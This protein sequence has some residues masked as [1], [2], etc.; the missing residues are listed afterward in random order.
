[1]VSLEPKPPNQPPPRRQAQAISFRA[2]TENPKRL[3][4]HREQK[5]NEKKREKNLDEIRG[6]VGGPTPRK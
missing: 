6:E 3:R 5:G 4:E 2:S 1:V